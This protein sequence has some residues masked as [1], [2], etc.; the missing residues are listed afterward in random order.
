MSFQVSIFFSLFHY[1]QGLWTIDT[2]WTRKFV[3]YK[4]SHKHELCAYLLWFAV[5]DGNEPPAFSRRD[6][7]AVAH[8]EV[9]GL[10]ARPAAH[11]AAAER[12]QLRAQVDEL[13]PLR[14]V[15]H[16]QLL[17]ARLWA[18]QYSTRHMHWAD[19]ITQIIINTINVMI[20]AKYLFL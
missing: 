16:R 1:Y 2:V 7:G 11:L 9:G 17:I 4:K 18:A 5:A 20:L 3:W 8:A 19:M 6:E 12:A 14:V 13:V 15:Q 10:A